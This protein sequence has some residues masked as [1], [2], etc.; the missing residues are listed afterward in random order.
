M[1]APQ[2]AVVVRKDTGELQENVDLIARRRQIARLARGEPETEN[3]QCSQRCT[4]D[5]EYAGKPDAQAGFS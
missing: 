2:D 4:G 1:L 3:R 5:R